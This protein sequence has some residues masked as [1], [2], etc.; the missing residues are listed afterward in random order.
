MRALPV[1][2]GHAGRSQGEEDEG[3]EAALRVRG[4]P[5][6]AGMRPNAAESRASNP[7]VPDREMQMIL[8]SFWE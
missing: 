4:T 2:E 6:L 5:V 1:R 8:S 3:C 7:G